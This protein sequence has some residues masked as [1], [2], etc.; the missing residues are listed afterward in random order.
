[1]C[2]VRLPEYFWI[3][4][5]NWDLVL[6]MLKRESFIELYKYFLLNNSPLRVHLDIQHGAYEVLNTYFPQTSY[7]LYTKSFTLLQTLHLV[8]C[9]HVCNKNTLSSYSSW[10]KSYTKN[11]QNGYCGDKLKSNFYWENNAVH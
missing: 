1:M 6:Y 11:L 5:L 7:C 2:N 9:L 10:N 3:L 4:Q 8:Q